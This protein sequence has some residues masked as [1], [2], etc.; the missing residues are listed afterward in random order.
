MPPLL[1]PFCL[2]YSDSPAWRIVRCI[3]RWCMLQM[4]TKRKLNSR[5]RISLQYLPIF[6]PMLYSLSLS[7]WTSP[8]QLSFHLIDGEEILA[9]QDLFLSCGRIGYIWMRV[10]AFQ[11]FASSHLT[12][13]SFSACFS[14]QLEMTIK[15][16]FLLLSSL[17]SGEQAWVLY[18]I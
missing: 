5:I 15:L 8:C 4:R 11:L 1:L 2:Q 18:N 17:L 12:I 16:L 13:S 3:Y 10:V 14:F 7:F 6:N 9:S